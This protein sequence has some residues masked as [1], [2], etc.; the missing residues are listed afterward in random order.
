MMLDQ[1]SILIPDRS[2]PGLKMAALAAEG[3]QG[4]TDK[5]LLIFVYIR[6]LLRSA[7]QWVRRMLELL[8]RVESSKNLR[9]K[10]TNAVMIIISSD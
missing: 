5:Q 1:Q 7:L 6:I 9:S 10:W 4:G 3:D 2:E 8:T